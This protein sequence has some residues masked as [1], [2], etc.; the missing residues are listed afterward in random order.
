MNLVLQKENI[1]Q[2]RLKELS[3]VMICH[4]NYTNSG[5]KFIDEKHCKCSQ[6]NKFQWQTIETKS[7]LKTKN[8][9]RRMEAKLNQ[10][11]HLPII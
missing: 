9:R 10:D 8:N 3:K 6:L 7:L 4:I 11:K 1:S 2:I 5:E